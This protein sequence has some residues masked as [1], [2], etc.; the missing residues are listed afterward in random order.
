MPKLLILK[1]SVNF[2]Y[3]GNLKVANSEGLRVFLHCT[4]GTKEIK[5]GRLSDGRIAE[6]RNKYSLGF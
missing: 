6:Q 2:T 4:E 3:W 5:T 1:V